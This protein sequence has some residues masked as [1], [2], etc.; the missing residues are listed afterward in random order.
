MADCS[1]LS[2]NE[3]INE[4]MKKVKIGTR[5][6][7]LALWQANYVRDGLIALHPHIEVELVEIVSE[8]DRTLDIPLH[9]AGGK[10]LF[11]KELE[12]CLL[13]G[14]IDLAVHSMKDVTIELPQGLHIPVVCEREDPRDALVSNQ[15]NSLNNLPP[16]S[17]I[18]TCSLRRQCQISRHFPHLTI[19]NLRGNV[20]TRLGKLDNGEY[21]AII[22]AVAGLVRLQMNHRISEAIDISIC[23]PAV[24]QGI[25]GIECREQDQWINS[26]I[27]PMNDIDAS[28]QVRAE[29]ATNARLGGGCH[30]PVAMYSHFTTHQGRKRLHLQALVGSVDGSRII[31]Y[32]QI[33]EITDPQALGDAVGVALLE[34]G[35]A[36]LLS[37]F[38]ASC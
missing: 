17:V 1:V 36:Q 25:V 15:Y 27:A 29:R 35:A 31:E 6:S 5:K 38:N 19:K 2:I 14:E 28:I 26:L 20:N 30:V 11:L 4:P 9:Q 22:L 34:Q 21:D 24:G 16:G 3:P 33:G 12:T 37:E 18:G 8:G 13:N 7:Q 23:L 32:E 10:G